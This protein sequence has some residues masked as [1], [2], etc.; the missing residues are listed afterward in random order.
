MGTR[1]VI[2]KNVFISAFG[3]HGKPLQAIRLIEKGKV[4]LI[5]SKQQLLE[6]ERVLRYPKMHFQEKDIKERLNF[7]LNV[8]QIV[9]ITGNMKVILEDPADNII[10]ETAVEH[11]ADYI[12]TGDRH[13]LK[14]KK[15]EKVQIVKP[16]EFLSRYERITE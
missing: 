4:T 7:I 5:M 15:Y 12:I 11:K 6:I 8:A 13:L 10:L 16:E 14:L 9:H 3:W 2:D 1:V